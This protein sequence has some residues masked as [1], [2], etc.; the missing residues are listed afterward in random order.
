MNNGK[1]LQINLK[2]IFINE[3]PNLQNQLQIMEIFIYL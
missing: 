1:G 2:I 3:G